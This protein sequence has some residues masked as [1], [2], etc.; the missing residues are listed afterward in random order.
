[1]TASLRELAATGGMW[2]ALGLV[3]LDEGHNEHWEVNDDGELM[4]SVELHNHGRIV[5]AQ[6]G[7]DG[8]PANGDWSIP[9]PD[10]EVLVGFADGEVE[11]EAVIV[12]TL[13]G[14]Q[15][16]AGLIP[17]RRIV[18]SD[19]LRLVEG[20]ADENLVLGQQIKAL[21]IA[22]LDALIA[23]THPTPTGPS[24]PPANAATF[25]AE[26]SK[27]EAEAILSQKAR[28]S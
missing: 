27:V 4:V 28:T 2:C 16:P 21:L 18:K 12:R 14:G 19:D 26:K 25:T 17:G 9:D 13:S 1:M 5:W 22:I 7:P 15:V 10:T 23:H 3:A 8:D 11:G 24:G 6:A 20:T